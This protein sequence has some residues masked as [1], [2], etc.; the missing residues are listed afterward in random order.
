M[1]DLFPKKYRTIVTVLWKNNPGT[2]GT[3]Q[4]DVWY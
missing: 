2:I 3:V 1:K 4:P